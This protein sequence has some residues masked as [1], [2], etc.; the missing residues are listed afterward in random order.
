[1][2]RTDRPPHYHNL[3]GQDFYLVSYFLTYC[4]EAYCVFYL[5][6]P[7]NEMLIWNGL[8]CINTIAS[9]I[10]SLLFIT[11]VIWIYWSTR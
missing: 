4:L 8:Y 10:C 7:A 3:L 9:S 5:N 11:N 1:M 6:I 2:K